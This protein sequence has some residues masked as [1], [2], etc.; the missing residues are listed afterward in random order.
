VIVRAEES[1]EVGVS[2]LETWLETSGKPPR[3]EALKGRLL[4]LLNGA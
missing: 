1:H 2:Q 3:E 4:E